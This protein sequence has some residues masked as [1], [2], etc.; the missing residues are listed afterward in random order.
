MRRFHQLSKS[1]QYIAD[2]GTEP[3]GSG[4]VH[5]EPGIYLCRRCDLPLYLSNDQFEAGCGWPSFDDELEG[6]ILRVPDGDRIEIRCSRCS[7]HLGHV[8]E[9]EGFTS[10]NMRH[11][12]NS[13]AMRFL[14]AIVDH[15]QRVFF[16]GGCFWGIE[17]DFSSYETR[18]GY[19]G[20]TWVDPTYEEVCTGQTG[21]TEVVEVLFDGPFE[22]VIERFY[23]I[24]RPGLQKCQYKSVIFYLTKEQREIANRCKR[25]ATEVLPASFFYVAESYHQHYYD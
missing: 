7:A 14:P 20:G 3:P 2:G 4:K 9:N 25:G 13:I 23:E 24:H 15:K 12:V 18:V 17:R 19:M 10:K 1:E 8:F 6:A 22:K 21:H 16:G 11:C 5:K